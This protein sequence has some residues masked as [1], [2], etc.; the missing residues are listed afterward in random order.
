MNSKKLENYQL[1]NICFEL[2][3]IAEEFWKEKGLSQDEATDKSIRS[4]GK[5][6]NLNKR[7]R[8][9]LDELLQIILNEEAR[10]IRF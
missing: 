6:G 4:V 3:D 2:W 5:L 9:Q 8:K 7:T 1:S 10:Q